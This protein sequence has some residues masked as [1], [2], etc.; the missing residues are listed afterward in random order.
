M[1]WLKRTSNSGYF[2]LSSVVFLD[3]LLREFENYFC[4]QSQV[5]FSFADEANLEEQMLFMSMVKSG[6]TKTCYRGSTKL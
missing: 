6:S 2:L 5:Y 4:E 1:C 3:C